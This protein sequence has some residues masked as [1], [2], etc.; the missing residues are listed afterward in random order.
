V[1][2]T[3]TLDVIG[4]ENLIGMEDTILA[5]MEIGH[6][7]YNQYSRYLYYFTIKTSQNI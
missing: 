1:L 3:G 2:F 6:S 5:A 7:K 4:T